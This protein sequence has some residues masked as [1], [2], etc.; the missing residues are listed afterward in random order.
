VYYKTI[1]KKQFDSSSPYGGKMKALLLIIFTALAALSTSCYASSPTLT[2]TDW[3]TGLKNPWDLAFL[4]DSSV[5]YTEKCLGLSVR[6]T[7]GTIHR[8]IGTKGSSLVASDFFCQ[9][10]SG[11]HGVAVDPDFAS[12][13]WIYVFMPSQTGDQ[14]SNH[15]VR[16]TL[17]GAMTAVSDRKDIITDIAFKS[18]ANNWGGAGSHSGGRIRFGSDGYLYITTGDNHNGTLPQDLNRLGGKVLR[19]DRDGK[20]L[21]ANNTPSGG[22]SRIFTYGHRNVQ[23]IDFHPTTQQPFISEHGPGHSDEVTA[24]VAGGNGGW[25]PKPNPGVACEDNYCGYTSNKLDGTPTSMTDLKKFP[26]A[27]VPVVSNNDSQ[28]MG[29]A[30]FLKGEQWKDF[31]GRLAVGIMAGTRID[32]IEIDSS[33]KALSTL[34]LS[35]PA[36]RMRS[37]VQ[38]PDGYLYVATDSGSIWKVAP[39]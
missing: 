3:M 14:K 33:N 11:M 28:G 9:G 22:D 12:N 20:G 27:M 39:Q 21:A 25:D 1:Q 34:T 16:L 17:N 5:L 2:K 10:Q 24:L 6:K 31:N 15:I 36:D 29:P 8:L 7:D 32:V 26:Q 23:G 4:P 35:L 37:L 30:A 13:R 38:G 18:V 19:V